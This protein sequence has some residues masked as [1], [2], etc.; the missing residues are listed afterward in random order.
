MLSTKWVSSIKQSALPGTDPSA[1]QR[2]QVRTF[3][4]ALC[5]DAGRWIHRQLCEKTPQRR[6]TEQNQD[7]NPH[8]L[9]NQYTPR[10]Q[11]VPA[12]RCN[13]S[14]PPVGRRLG[15]LPLLIRIFPCLRRNR[16]W[17]RQSPLQSSDFLHDLPSSEFG[18]N[19]QVLSSCPWKSICR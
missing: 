12:E 16:R 8:H 4:Y 6:I 10:H 11:Q 3:N 5:V 18:V 9:H 1:E 15:L 14:G 2:S 13:Q 17:T 19:R 7:T